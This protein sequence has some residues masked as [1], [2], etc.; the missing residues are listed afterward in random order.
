MT[1]RLPRVIGGASSATVLGWILYAVLTWLRYGRPQR[2]GRNGEDPLDAFLADPEV[3]ELH[4]TRVRAPASLALAA[5]KELDLRHSPLVLSIF[6]LR[7]LPTRLRGGP[8]RWQWPGLVEGMLAIGWGVL[9]DIPGRLFVA[10]AVTQPWRADVEFRALAPE[11]FAAFDEPGYVKIVWTLEAEEVSELESI[12]R[13][14]TRVKTT[15]P[16]ARRRFRRYWAAF[17]PGILL[18]RY[19]MLRLVR[20]EAER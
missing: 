5:A 15:D 11:D 10:G 19:E 8:V 7:T 9:A 13:T 14:R 17:S 16:G 2:P 12:A 20:R 18:I 4:E 3:D 1:P 6:A